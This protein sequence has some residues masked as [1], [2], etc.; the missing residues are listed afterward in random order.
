[1]QD[2]VAVM[3]FQITDAL[4]KSNVIWLCDDEQQA[5][6]LAAA[7]AALNAAVIHIPSSDAMPGD[8]LPP[9]QANVAARMTVLHR[10]HSGDQGPVAYVL[11]A[12]AAACAW[13][14]QKPKRPMAIRAGDNLKPAEWAKSIESQGYIASD[15]VD[16]PGEFALRGAVIDLFPAQNDHPVR[17][18]LF[19][20]RVTAIRTYD[21][22]TQ[23]TLTA[24]EAATVVS[25]VESSLV[26]PICIL[27]LLEPG[28]MGMTA[29][30]DARR[31][32]HL[33]LMKEAECRGGASVAVIAEDAWHA[34]ASRW[35][36]AEPWAIEA[37]PRFAAERAPM[38]AC[39]SAVR[40]LLKEGRRLVLTG[41]ERDLRFLRPRLE[42]RLDLSLP[43]VTSWDEIRGMTEGKG[44]ALVMHLDTGFIGEKLIV[45]AA[46]DLLGSRAQVCNQQF[47]APSLLSRVELG[48]GDLAVHEDHGVCRIAGLEASPDGSELIILEYAKEGRRLLPVTDAHRLW[49]YGA[50]GEAVT[51]DTLDGHSWTR[52]RAKVQE[53]IE[54]SARALLDIA[55]KKA[56]MIAPIL[57]PDPSCYEK[58]VGGFAFHETA[59]QSRAISAVR[60]DLASG[61]PMDRLVIGDVGYGKTEVAL[62]AA[63]FAALAGHQVVVV[64]PTTVL[65]RQHLELFQRRFAGTRVKV[66]ELS[67]LSSPG[68]RKA[69]KAGLADGSIAICIG[70]GAVMGPSVRYARLSLVVIDEEQRFGAADKTRLRGDGTRHTLTLSATPIP[71]SLQAA[72]VG[73]QAISVIATAPARRRPVRTSVADAEDGLIRTALSREKGR[74][75]QSFVVVPRI[76]DI[77]SVRDRITRLMPDLCL[78]EAHGEMPAIELDAAVV[79]FAGGQGDVLLATNIIEA[80]LDIPRANTMIVWRADRF[81]LAQLHQMRGRVGRGTRRGQVLLLTDAHGTI[82]PGTLE[83]LRTMETFDQLGAGFDISLRD[84]DMR[85]SGDLAG[86]SQTGHAMLIGLDLYQAL[87]TRALKAARGEVMETWMPDLRLG[88][89]GSLTEAWI[90]DANVRLGLYGRLARLGNAASLDAF[91]E[92]LLDRFGPLP[93]S[94]KTLIAHVRIAGLA[95]HLDVERVDAGPAAFALTLR[96]QSSAQPALLGFHLKEGRWILQ[97]T[98]DYEGRLPKVLALFE[99]L[100]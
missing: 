13:P 58:F 99:E 30:A 43:L 54:Q 1:M 84:L 8:A 47:D 38:A 88:G 52:R 57:D 59:D 53:G 80:G 75:G 72:L 5:E 40:P 46:A 19:E 26:D 3:A 17:L 44:S 37:L 68:Q 62:R 22:A 94:A 55:E 64:A 74:G 31:Q 60:D 4:K 35:R 90:P 18:D 6:A 65:V 42:K 83:R 2:S 89:G 61:R 15:R 11:S 33:A 29:K 63:A 50:D 36:A 16:D 32:R 91:E 9:T 87:L 67:R 69:V 49:R 41:S 10:L 45:L 48:I 92:E 23:R 20:G 81:G 77:A 34:A 71:R 79:A 78:V 86:E 98:T 12:E 97:K 56:A 76:A 66:A 14:S 82:A 85:G 73:L 7:I 28:L 51:L 25:A 100:V 39:A 95:R 24:V 96:A 27:D 70:T 21:P 93:A